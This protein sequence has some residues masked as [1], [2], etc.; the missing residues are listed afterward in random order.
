MSTRTHRAGW[1]IRDQNAEIS[2][3]RHAERE[4]NLADMGERLPRDWTPVRRTGDETSSDRPIRRSKQGQMLA[5]QIV[6]RICDEGLAVGDVLPPEQVMMQEFE[7]GRATYREAVRLLEANGVVIVQPGPGGGPRVAAA[8]SKDLANAMRLHLQL[9]NTTYAD[10]ARARCDIEPLLARITAERQDAHTIA[11]IRQIVA[12]A[13]L[14]DPE[15]R[16][17]VCALVRRFHAALGSGSQNTVVDLVGSLLIEVDDP[18]MTQI[19]LPPGEM[20]FVID[21]WRDV[22]DAI[23]AGRADDAERGVRQILN[24]YTEYF[25]ETYADLAA[26]SIT[27][28]RAPQLR[29]GQPPN[30]K[31]P[32]RGRAAHFG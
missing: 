15:D 14:T 18:V 9:R 5:Q 17:G 25:L 32:K 3:G 27:W 26:Q 19:V 29:R 31:A 12:D 28:T 11:V 24:R 20:A 8:G 6:D 16:V 4:S 21:Q 30:H 23:S 2:V 13:A 10:V 7:V 1:V 22:A